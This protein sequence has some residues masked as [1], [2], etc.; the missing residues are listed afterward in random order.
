[1]KTVNLWNLDADSIKLR[2]KTT[3]YKEL[4]NLKTAII[5]KA[6]KTSYPGTVIDMLNE[7]IEPDKTIISDNK[8]KSSMDIEI[9]K[10]ERTMNE[11]DKP[12]MNT[13]ETDKI[14]NDE[15]NDT[16]KAGITNEIKKEEVDENLVNKK[17]E[18]LNQMD[19]KRKVLDKMIADLTYAP[20][21]REE[22][23]IRI[24]DDEDWID[25]IEEEDIA[26]LHINYLLAQ[27]VHCI[28]N[29]RIME[30]DRRRDALEL[31]IEKEKR[32]MRQQKFMTNPINPY[33]NSEPQIINS[34]E[35]GKKG[36]N[37]KHKAYNASLSEPAMDGGFQLKL[38]DDAIDNEEIGGSIDRY[39]DVASKYK[40]G[41]TSSRSNLDPNACD[42]LPQQPPNEQLFS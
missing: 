17:K 11:E 35:R 15:K 1:M 37:D 41:P 16:D 21:D 13:V 22:Q 5:R 24:I 7:L 3:K 27:K 36:K 12:G 4:N 30:R 40:K 9:A 33:A 26:E 28:V 10:E 29:D 2:I 38:N 20:I 34:V 32:Q 25:A 14:S 39:D 23:K 18:L 8:K 31:Q 6:A 19:E 42:Y